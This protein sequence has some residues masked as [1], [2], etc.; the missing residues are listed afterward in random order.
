[1]FGYQRT[2]W[3]GL[4]T[5]QIG[6][7]NITLGGVHEKFV[8]ALLRHREE[9]PPR[10]EEPVRRRRRVA[11][12]RGPGGT[13][14]TL[15]VFGILI[16]VMGGMLAVGMVGMFILMAAG[17][18]ALPYLPG[19]RVPGPGP[20]PVANVEPP[21]EDVVVGL[22][23]VVPDGG[24]GGLPWAPLA[25]AGQKKT[26][27]LLDDAELDK[28]LAD[29]KSRNPQ[30]VEAA[31][32]KLAKARPTEARRKEVA[33]ALQAAL[34]D[35]FPSAREGAAEGLGQWGTSDDVPALVRM[36]ADP[37]PDTRAVAMSALAAIKD[38]QG[39][40]AVAQ[41]LPDFFDREKARQALE[42]MGPVGAKAVVPMLHHA[43]PQTR[44]EACGVLQAVGVKE[45]LPAL[46]D[47]TR[48]PNPNVAQAAAD[49][50][51]AI[52]DRP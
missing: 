42:A 44:I 47:A 17:M 32:K 3:W 45:N 13:G 6:A 48:D 4:R 28:A 35:L 31:G 51:K 21:P 14:T 19:P 22:L 12:G 41:R 5:V 18:F 27:N 37:F 40:A 46:Q 7:Y 16:L 39:A 10:R 49:A 34:D 9:G 52:T 20:V 11:V 43:D 24:P 8:S 38:E 26:F 25:L 1:L 2:A 23:A 15:K 29:L 33:K 36:L 50:V 30:A